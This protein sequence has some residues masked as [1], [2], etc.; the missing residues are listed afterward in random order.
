MP[1]FSL[2][3]KY[4]IGTLGKNAF[5][6]IDFLKLSGQTYWQMLPVG[7]TSYG[8]SPYQSFSAFAGSHYYIDLETLVDEGLLDL[9]DIEGIEWESEVD[10]VDYALLYENRIPVLKKAFSVF[11]ENI[12]D[13][14]KRFC[15]DAFWLNDYA[16]FMSLKDENSGKPWNMWDDGLKFRKKQDIKAAEIRLFE[17]IEFYK[18]L[19]Y[20]FFKQWNAVK[21]YA[22]KNSILLIG[23]MPI[24]VSADSADCWCNPELFQ[25][26][27]ELEP[28]AV[29]GCP[30]DAFSEDGQLW[31]NPLYHWDYMKNQSIPYEW[32]LKRMSM[33]MKM[34]DLIR[35]DHFRGFQAYYSIPV[36]SLTA[37]KGHWED[38]PGAEF[39]HTLEKTL[40]TLPVIAEDL[41]ILT[42]DVRE[43]LEEV[44]YPG[45]KVLQFAFDSEGD[46][47][48]LPHNC[49]ENCVLYTGTHDN[50]TI[51]GWAKNLSD[52][53][54]SFAKEYMRIADMDS[55]N[56]SIIKVA[57][58]ST[59]KICIF[60]MQDFLGLSSEGR[61]NI[62][63]TLGGNWCWRIAEG[64]INSWLA[65]IIRENTELYRRCKKLKP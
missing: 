14:Y 65:G 16:L 1:L 35:I 44:A 10:R 49:V 57:M 39:F 43:M 34:F 32:W 3:G 54:L 8:D 48:Y 46:S 7:P 55:L 24:Y 30:P 56:W 15:N 38:G 17:E 62:P 26:D 29:A 13:D 40:G 33:A 21:E 64:C 59:A 61:I 4:G 52:N 31:G 22:H 19:Q 20:L 27:D 47:S 53:D 63:S 58:A 23:D 25:L 37:A 18:F 12:P 5:E 28:V 41:G 2:S 42:D 45:M 9:S 36:D 11:L 6:F 51:V 60:Q 50:D